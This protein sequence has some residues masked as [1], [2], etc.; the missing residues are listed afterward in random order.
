MDSLLFDAVAEAL[1]ISALL[2]ALPL[3]VTSLVGLAC[4][5]LQGATQIQDPTLT[6]LPKLLSLTLALLVCGPTVYSLWQ[7][8]FE[9][10][11]IQVESFK[12]GR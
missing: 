2:L 6:L 5:V 9:D 1:K 11:F 8:Y 12:G 4:A 10:I 3:V 7:S